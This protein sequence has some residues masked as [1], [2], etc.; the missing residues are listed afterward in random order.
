MGIN[1][2]IIF[3]TLSM[4]QH[5]RSCE[6]G[7]DPCKNF[8]LCFYFC[9]Y[10]PLSRKPLEAVKSQK[11]SQILAHPLATQEHQVRPIQATNTLQSK[12]AFSI[13]SLVL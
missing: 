1:E 9:F 2:G 5:L 7:E 4:G 11:R 6:E 3:A 12:A 8:F 13:N 10:I